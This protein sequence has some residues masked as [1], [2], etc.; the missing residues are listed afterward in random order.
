M[1]GPKPEDTILRLTSPSI[2]LLTLQLVHKMDGLSKFF[3]CFPVKWRELIV[4]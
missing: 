3:T 2:S 4:K 1:F